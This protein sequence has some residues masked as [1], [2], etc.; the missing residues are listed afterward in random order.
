MFYE[1]SCI[2]KNVFYKN[3]LEVIENGRMVNKKEITFFL[4]KLVP[5][6]SDCQQC[7]HISLFTFASIR[8]EKIKIERRGRSRG[9]Y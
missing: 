7:M 8:N 1:L 9:G 4:P 2:D 6:F 5:F 3:D